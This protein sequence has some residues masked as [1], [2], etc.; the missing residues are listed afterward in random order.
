ME[1]VLLAEDRPIVIKAMQIIFE[2]GLPDHR[3]EI[4][5]NVSMLNMALKNDSYRLLVIG[6][7]EENNNEEI[8]QEI[9]NSYPALEIV[10]LSHS[11][12]DTGVS[13][14]VRKYIKGILPDGSSD[15]EITLA[16]KTILSERVYCS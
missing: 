7:Q 9:S 12:F 11:S 3:L 4:V 10:A 1:K 15:T 2:T 5:R 14:L 13:K 16:L 8:F 6:L